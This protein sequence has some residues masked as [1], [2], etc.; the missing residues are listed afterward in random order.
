M[1][2]H[3]V[4]E[5]KLRDTDMARRKGVLGER[6]RPLGARWWFRG[7]FWWSKTRELIWR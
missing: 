3:L 5:L 6:R 7:K 2:T 1:S 4:L